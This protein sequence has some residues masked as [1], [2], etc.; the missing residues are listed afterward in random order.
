MTTAF[1]TLLIGVVG[2]AVLLA[3]IAYLWVN[4]TPSTDERFDE[5]GRVPLFGV[6]LSATSPA[7]VQMGEVRE[8]ETAPAAELT[9]DGQTVASTS[10]QP[11]APGLPVS[12]HSIEHPDTVD[13]SMPSNGNGM[14]PSSA[15]PGP[16]RS[17][18]LGGGGWGP[19]RGWPSEA[20]LSVTP[21]FVSPVRDGM[22]PPPSSHETPS[23]GNGVHADGGS[24]FEGHGL[25]YSTPLE[26]TLQFLP[27]RL[28]ITSGLDM[29]REIRFVR[30]P[31]PNETQVTF[32]RNEGPLY[33][34]I[35]L[36]DQTVSREHAKM[37]LADGRWLLTNL[38]NTNPVAHNGRVLSPGEHQTLE[39]GDR[40]EM[41]EVVFS[42]RS[43]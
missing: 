42:F 39:D 3:F 14:R 36:R 43:R 21:R 25:R 12:A 38:S 23:N 13:A 18:R 31:G 35:Q 10:A 28:E 1:G 40:L 8:G 5:Y 6:D 9:A 15:G 19:S 2:A 17:N 7:S 24:M 4:R 37:T 33:R 26:G 29:G 32:G 30:V 11:F 41:G 34:H 22:R 27:G 16:T 20:E